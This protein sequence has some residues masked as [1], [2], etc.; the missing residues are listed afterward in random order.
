MKYFT[1]T[2]GAPRPVGPY[3]PAVQA[4][5]LVFVSGQVGLNP[6]TMALVAGGLEAETRQALA[7]LTAV[8]K[9]SGL[10]PADVVMSSIFLTQMSDFKKV[11]EIYGQW[12]G[13]GP[14]PARQTLGVKELPLGACVE[15]SLIASKKS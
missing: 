4:G 2:P 10:S 14:Y 9:A 7:N 12:L 1:D 13:E 6:E 15:V 11:N 5:D 8:L 3:T